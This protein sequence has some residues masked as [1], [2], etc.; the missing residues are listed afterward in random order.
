[1]YFYPASPKMQNSFIAVLGTG[2]TIAGQAESMGD[3]VG[4]K[5]GTVSVQSL[6]AAVPALAHEALRFEQ[7]AQIDSKDMSESLWQRLAHRVQGLLDDDEIA[8]VV[9]THGTDT[10]EET[11]A[12]LAWTLQARKPVVLT[13]AMRPASA[14][15]PDG[16]PNLRDAVTVARQG[17]PGVVAVLNGVIWDGLSVRKIHPYS[18]QAFDGGDQ[19][20]VGYVEEGMVRVVAASLSADGPCAGVRAALRQGR[21]L[22]VPRVEVVFNHAGA[23]GRLLQSLL[24]AHRQDPAWTLDGIVA[25]GTGNGTL[26]EGLMAALLEAQALG[27]EVQLATRTGC[28]KVVA[29]SGLA[30]PLAASAQ[31]WKARVAL[32][33][34]LM[35]RALAR[36]MPAGA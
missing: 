25:A 32:Q 15:C 29:P 11:A 18:V 33:L 35:E 2:G 4:Y 22:A 27:I 30:F 28:G 13:A 9:I 5:A 14:L 7:L 8:G 19:G 6:V 34:M 1:M 36:P 26:S 16:P 10:L 17:P 21:M 12:F 24:A 23:D 20:P 31:P 3:Q